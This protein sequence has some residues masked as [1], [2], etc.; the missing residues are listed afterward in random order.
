MGQRICEGCILDKFCDD[1]KDCKGI[2]GN[3]EA[4]GD[5]VK[6][7]ETR[8][9]VNICGYWLDDQTPFDNYII[10]INDLTIRK[11]DDQIFYYFNSWAQVDAACKKETAGE[12][13]IT[14]I[15]AL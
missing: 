6:R 14:S 13:V 5:F 9:K 4:C 12:F 11:D 7:L 15:E 3:V 10:C 1:C 8:Q 2:R